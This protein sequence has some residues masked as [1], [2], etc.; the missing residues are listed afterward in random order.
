[1]DFKASIQGVTVQYHRINCTKIN[2][3]EERIEFY[4]VP[5]SQSGMGVYP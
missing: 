4:G 2:L 3:Q 5:K 1:M